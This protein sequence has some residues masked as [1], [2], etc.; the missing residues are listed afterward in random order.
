MFTRSHI[1]TR[2]GACLAVLATLVLNTCFNTLAWGDDEPQG[3]SMHT[4]FGKDGLAVR[5]PAISQAELLATLNQAHH[6]LSKQERQA[7]QVI[8]KSSQGKDAVI[9]AVMPGGLLYYA[10]KQQKLSD[11][12]NTLTEVASE[13]DGLDVD[14]VTLYDPAGAIVIA[15]YP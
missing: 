12:K 9:A 3:Y 10:Y 8:D 13:L 2:P 7:Q 14:A 6:L 4:S 15:R 5:L 11:A 1:F